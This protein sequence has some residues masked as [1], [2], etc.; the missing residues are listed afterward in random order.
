MSN[1]S[2]K[3][4]LFCCAICFGLLFFLAF[5]AAEN[6]VLIFGSGLGF[7]VCVGLVLAVPDDTPPEVPNPH[8]EAIKLQEEKRTRDFIISARRKSFRLIKGKKE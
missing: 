7:L 5:A 2:F 1:K 3:Q 6:P 4:A 8:A